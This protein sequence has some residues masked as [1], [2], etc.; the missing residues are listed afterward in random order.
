MYLKI[1]LLTFLFLL[2]NC[3]THRFQSPYSDQAILL[4]GWEKKCN[5]ERNYTQ[6][7][8]FWGAYPINKIEEKELFP[9]KTKSYR[10]SQTTSLLDG[11]ISALGG[12]T[13]S[14][15]RKTWILED[16]NQVIPATTESNK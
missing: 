15:T 6:W 9:S 8:L 4:E 10:L 13:L 11:V 3:V 7:Y 14:V 5:G 2:Q 16:C 12:M 1:V